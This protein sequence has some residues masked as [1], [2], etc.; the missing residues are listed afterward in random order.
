MR[1]ARDLIGLSVLCIATGKR[2]GTVRDLL[3]DQ[4]W[5]VLGILLDAKHWFSSCRYIH[6]DDI[7]ACGPDALT[8]ED[9]GCIRD[10]AE[11]EELGLTA[12]HGGKHRLKELPVVTVNGHQLGVIEDV[13]LLEKLGTKIVGFELSEGFV[14]DLKEGRKWLPLPVSLT[15]GEDAVIVPLTSRL[16]VDEIFVSKEE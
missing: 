10:S 12:F 5:T 13:Y 7:L 3:F 4:E 1:K 9:A 14:S 2:V 16:E 15:I 8:I 11:A 6:A